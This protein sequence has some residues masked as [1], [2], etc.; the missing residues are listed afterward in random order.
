MLRADWQFRKDWETMVEARSLQLPDIDQSR[1][2]FLVAVYRQFGEHF[3]AGLGYNFT[4]F[5]DDLTDLSYD[6]QGAFIN[7]IGML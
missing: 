5:S 7:V 4:D 3:K 2:G 1:A 6:H